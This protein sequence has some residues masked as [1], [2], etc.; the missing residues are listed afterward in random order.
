MPACIS[1]A[2]LPPL[3]ISSL[4]ARLLLVLHQLLGHRVQHESKL[5]WRLHSKHHAI[6]TPSPFSTLFIDPT[7]AALQVRFY[8]HVLS[9]LHAFDDRR[10]SVAQKQTLLALLTNCACQDCAFHLDLAA[11]A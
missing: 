10:C 9:N 11:A 3:F 5:L 8:N 4:P 1:L 7:D 6:D 2:C